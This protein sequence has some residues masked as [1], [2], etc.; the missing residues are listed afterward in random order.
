MTEQQIQLSPNDLA[1]LLADS[2]D[3]N[4]S[5]TTLRH[6]GIYYIPHEINTQNLTEIQQDI[7][8]K[9]LSGFNEELQIIINSIGGAAD[10]TWALINL[11]EF[12][13]QDITTIGI[14]SVCSAATQILAAGTPGK[15][16]ATKN[17][18]LMTHRFSCEFGGSEAELVAAGKG[19]KLEHQRD[20]Q[21]WLEHSNLKTIKEVES[22][23][24]QQTDTWM[25]T[26]DAK[27]L[28]IIDTII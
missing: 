13:K 19:V 2:S 15:R 18:L 5:N 3:Q 16:K 24:L 7:L 28:G 21:F 25:T 6:M 11:M 12:V 10:P 9:H 22:K 27:K 26:K 20:L 4:D 1:S 14:G 23:I 8:L 17:A